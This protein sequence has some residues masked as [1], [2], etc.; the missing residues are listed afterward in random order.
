MQKKEKQKSKTKIDR[1]KSSTNEILKSSKKGNIK[2]TL[3]ESTEKKKR[4]ERKKIN[5]ERGCNQ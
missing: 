2:T 4:N 1:E 3:K 5:W